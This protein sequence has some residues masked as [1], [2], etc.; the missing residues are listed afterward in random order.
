M[1]NFFAALVCL[2][3]VACEQSNE[4][5]D[6]LSFSVSNLPALPQGA[7]HYQLW[8][9]YYIFN[10][11][12]GENSPLHEG[13]FLSVGEFNFA[14]DG[15]LRSLNGGSPEFSLPPGNDPQLLSDICIA[16]QT[17]EVLAK[18]NHE[19]PGSILIGGKFHGDA[20]N[21]I[22]DLDIAF[23]SGL[24]TNF[25]SVSGK[26]TIVAP[27]SPPDSNLGVWFV[28]LGSAPT[29]G[30]K[31]LPALPATWKYEG[32]VVEQVANASPAYYSTGKFARADSAD[33]DG[34]G[35]NGGTTGVA[36]NFPGQDF[37]RGAFHPNLISTQYT[38]LVTV[39]PFPDNSASP[40]F[41]HL[42]KTSPPQ[43]ITRTQT[44]QNVIFTSAPTARIVI[45]R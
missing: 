38:F 10:K 7:G 26:C 28:E 30:L 27:T 12:S 41:L 45:R 16:V 43:S 14:D 5:V 13:D 32:W 4:V 1:K 23:A 22:A 40:F 34:S 17:P 35:P 11:V 36:Y 19:E 24:K 33:Y 18:A 31:N 29:A 8:V 25:S 3:F 42:L 15:S 20:S 21:A 44:L 39:E 37:V 9:R 6:P 2:C